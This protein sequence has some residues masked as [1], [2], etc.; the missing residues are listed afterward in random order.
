VLLYNSES[1]LIEKTDEKL[2]RGFQ[3]TVLTTVLGA[4][5]K[6]DPGEDAKNILHQSTKKKLEFPGL[7]DILELVTKRTY[8]AWHEHHG[9]FPDELVEAE[10]RRQEEQET[11]WWKKYRKD[12]E[13]YKALRKERFD[14]YI[15]RSANDP[16]QS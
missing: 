4:I 6:T 2:L 3:H 16:M 14:N 12:M 5:E 13:D 9:R 10:M 7:P 8:C 1:W 11:T 15:E